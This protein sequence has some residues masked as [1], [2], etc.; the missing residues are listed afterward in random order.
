M[1]T[2]EAY[3]NNPQAIFL[4]GGMPNTETFPFES[5]DITYKGNT[6]QRLEGPALAAALQYGPSR[7]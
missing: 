2:A 5:I 4:A 3:I 1:F 7:G 6:H